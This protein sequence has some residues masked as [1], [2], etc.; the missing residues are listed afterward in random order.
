[1]AARSGQTR[2]PAGR[3]QVLRAG[4]PASLAR[5]RALSRLRQR[6]GDPQRVRRHPTS[7]AA[8]SVQGVRRAFRRPHRHGAGRT[9]SAAAGVGALPLPYGSEPL[10]PADRPGAE[11]EPVRCAGHDRTAA[12]RSGGPDPGGE[13]GGRGG[14][15]RGLRRGRPQGP[16][17]G[18]RSKGRS[19]RRRKLRGRPGRGTSEKD[20]PPIVGLIQR[21]GPVVLH[22]LANVQQRTIEPVITGAIAQGTLIHTDEYGIYARLPT[23]GYQH[24]TV[25][26]ARGEYARDEDGDGFCEVHVNTMEGFWSLLRSWLRPHRGISQDKLPLYLGFFQFV[27]NARRRGRALLSALVAGLVA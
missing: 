27:H 8:L 20:K 26:H 23:W 25:C 24:K 9:P 21:G 3:R 17:R 19:G 16:T 4:T 13:A 5:G 22:M 14:D 2:G 1:M 6:C 7:S 18:R 11:A 12:P 10:E 15:R